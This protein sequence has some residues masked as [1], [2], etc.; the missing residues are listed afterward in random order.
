MSMKFGRRDLL[1]KSAL[2]SM[3][4]MAGGNA[5]AQDEDPF[6]P[7]RIENKEP[8]RYSP[9]SYLEKVK[10][11]LEPAMA[12]KATSKSEAEK[13]QKDARKKLWDVLGESH[14]PSRNGHNARQLEAP[15]DVGGYTREKWELELN[16]G[17]AMPFYVL[18]PLGKSG[19]CKTAVCLHGHGNGV[20]DI[21]GMPV[22]DEA[23]ELIGILNEDYAVKTV[24]EGWI[25]VAPELWSFGE[26]LDLVEGAR[27]GFDGG[28]EKPHLNAITLGKSS[29]GI[30]TKDVVT[31]IDWISTQS[32]MDMDNLTCMGLSGGGMMTMYV[33]ALDVRIKRVLIAGYLTE[34]KG[35]I[36]GVRHCGCNYVPGL[37]KCMDFPD[38]ASLIAPRRL[39]AVSGK[40]DA[41]FPV[42]SFRAAAKKVSN[43]YKVMGVP[44][45]FSTKE[46]GGFHSFDSGAL[47]DILS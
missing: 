1:K 16:P 32:E 18:R 37:A 34:M 27:P 38:I 6:P 45:K 22:D 7:M 25:A 28:C 26:R 47:K 40:R 44:G 21:A 9:L 46:H 8:E 35:S 29:I 3:G 31:L 20:K 17:S 24:K 2:V 19:K 5:S 41:I 39:L 30:R 4:M 11:Q 23:S 13:W 12:F 43:V 42:D 14:I 10:A 15:T 36:L 33:S